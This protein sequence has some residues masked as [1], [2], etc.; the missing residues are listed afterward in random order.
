M[1]VMATNIGISDQRA[2]RASRERYKRRG[3]RWYDRWVTL[4]LFLKKK[5]HVVAPRH[6]KPG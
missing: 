6:P 3:G 4:V 1:A 2:E 5:I